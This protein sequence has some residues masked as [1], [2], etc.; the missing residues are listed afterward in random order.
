MF[1][2]ALELHDEA[3]VLRKLDIDK[4][5][6]N[7]KYL[8][9]MLKK[10]STTN[11]IFFF[12]RTL[13]NSRILIPT[14]KNILSSNG[15]PQDF[16][17]LAMAESNFQT[18]AHSPKKAAGMWQFIPR[19]AQIYQLQMDKYIDERRDIVKSTQAAAQHLNFLH[20]EFGKWYLA[21]IAYNCGDGRLIEA[22]KEAHSDDLATLI[23]VKKKYLPRESRIY[24]RKVIALALLGH[25]TELISQKLQKLLSVSNSNSLATVELQSGERLERIAKLI[26]MPYKEL[27]KLNRH[28]KYNFTPP[29][30]K[31]CSVHIPH[32]KLIT[33]KQKYKEKSI[34]SIYY[35]HNVTKGETL[36]YI[37]KMYGV[38]YRIIMDFNKMKSSRLQI[39]QELIIPVKKRG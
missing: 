4:S 33:F 37:G 24:I 32:S 39:N 3:G 34:K 1:L 22:I 27:K 12:K 16:L 19:T 6:L 23:D 18:K 13:N 35:V 15:V 14:I 7:D 8:K 30:T 9:K 20:N 2:L 5:F 10:Q 17:Y 31:R 28:L 25:D 11:N 29:Y 38:S 21:I 36:G 26:D